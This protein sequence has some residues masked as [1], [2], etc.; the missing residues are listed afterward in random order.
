ML[1]FEEQLCFFDQLYRFSV[2]DGG[3]VLGTAVDFKVVLG[4]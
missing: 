2:C 4:I 1:L 3:A